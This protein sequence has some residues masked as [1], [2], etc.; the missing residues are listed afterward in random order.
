MS[1]KSV[2]MINYY[3]LFAALATILLLLLGFFLRQTPHAR[4]KDDNTS[5]L[6]E[7]RTYRI[8][9]LPLGLE[10]SQLKKDLDAL[11]KKTS[12]SETEP[13]RVLSVSVAAHT[14]TYSCATVTLRGVRPTS[15]HYSFDESFIGMTPLYD[16]G[17]KSKIE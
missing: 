16:N 15:K 5:R 7:P 6:I 4:S 12:G 3:T 9:G 10:T 14:S 11:Y 17:G 8:T 2:E 13:S 1:V